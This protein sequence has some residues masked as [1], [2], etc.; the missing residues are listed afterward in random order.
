M[1][2]VDE[3]I[4][5]LSREALPVNPLGKPIPAGARLSFVLLAYAVGTQAVLGLRTDLALQFTRF[6]FVAEIALLLSLLIAG[7]TACVLSAYPDAYQRPRWLTLPYAAFAI[8]LG[9]LAVELVLPGD[10]RM[11]IL[12]PGMSGMECAFCIAAVA[13]LPSAWIFMLLR[14]GASVHPWQAGV[15]AVLTASAVGCLT[16]RLSEANDSLLHVVGWHYLPTVLFAMLGAW[17]GKRLL[18]W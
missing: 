11:V 16:L 7:A 18:S 13:L 2:N 10:H 3:L 12:S 9:L 14:K 17:L 15:F 4:G 5:R 6:A 8:L 1:K